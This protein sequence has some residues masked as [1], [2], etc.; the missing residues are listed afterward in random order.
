VK[1]FE[2][3]TKSAKLEETAF[4]VTES[5]VKIDGWMEKDVPAALAGANKGFKQLMFPGART[6]DVRF[7]CF[8]RENMY[9]YFQHECLLQYRGESVCYKLD[10]RYT[11]CTSPLKVALSKEGLRERLKQ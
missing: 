8:R 1:G 4:R 5:T 6:L 3:S 11:R 10:L 7:V 9:I 2:T